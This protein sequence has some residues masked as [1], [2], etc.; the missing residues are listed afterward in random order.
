MCFFFFSSRRRHTSFS[1]DWSSDVCSSDLLWR[2][3]PQVRRTI[4]GGGLSRVL[5]ALIIGL[6]TSA[7]GE[8]IGYAWGP[9][10][11]KSR[12]FTLECARDR[13]VKTV[14]APRRSAAG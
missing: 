9:G 12:L 6:I 7:F 4:G 8:M 14:A 13:H 3:G 11:A 1:R 5:P 2:V 10:G